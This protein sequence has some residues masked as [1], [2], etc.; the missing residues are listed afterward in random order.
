MFLQLLLKLGQRFSDNTRDLAGQVVKNSSG[1]LD[2]TRKLE[3]DEYS[4]SCVA[5]A[6]GWERTGPHSFLLRLGAEADLMAERTVS[7]R[8]ESRPEIWQSIDS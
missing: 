8:S 5:S 7:L 6:G 2:L 3:H 1:R 4:V